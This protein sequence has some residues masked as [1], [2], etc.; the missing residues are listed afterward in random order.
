LRAEHGGLDL[1]GRQHQRRQV[2]SL[3]QDVAHAGLAADRHPLPDQGGDVAIDRA[4]RGFQLLGD[5]V[6]GQRFAGAAE[7]LDD[8]KQPV[9]ASHARSLFPKVS[10]SKCRAGC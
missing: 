1:V 9:G 6:R 5:G 7:H 8:L 3:F 4:F 2:E 10:F